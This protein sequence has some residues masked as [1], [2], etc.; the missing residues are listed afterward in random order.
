MKRLLITLAALT[1]LAGGSLFA[2]LDRGSLTGLVTDPSGASVANAQ[3]TATHADTNTTFSTRS[4]E[5]G[6]YTLP[7]LAIGRYRIIV[8]ATGFRRTQRD[9]I[10]VTSGDSLRAD[11]ILELGSVTDSVQV[12]AQASAIQTESTRVATNLTTKLVEDLPLVVAGQIR[13][14]FNLAVIAPEAKS[15]STFRI[16]GG[17]GSGWDMQMDGVSLASGTVTY[18]YE[19][20][21][22]SSV[23][24]DAIAEFNVESSGMKAEYG[25]AM[26]VV[27][28]ATKAGTNQLHG[29]V[30]DY[31]RN[32]A[33]DA[34]GFFAK[35]APVLKQN[36]FG[37]TVGGPVYIPKIYNGKNRTFFFT[38]FEGFRNRSGNLPA[39]FTVPL[40]EMYTGDFR[41]YIKNGPDGV[42]FMMQIYDP[43]ST[44][45]GADGR[46]TRTPFAGN[47]I[48]QA[49]FSSV[50]TKYMSFRD[51]SMVANV[52]GAGIVSNYFRDRGTNIS[53]WTKYSVRADHQ[54]NTS[55]HLSFL[56]MDGTKEDK[57]GA[58]GPPGLPGNLN[59]GQVWSRK[60]IS[61]VSPG[62]APS[63]TASS[64][65]S[66]LRIRRKRASSPTSAAWTEASSGQ[67]SSD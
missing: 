19:R 23:P 54:I 51:P 41:N 30:F 14:V 3:V 42:P 60:N 65:A 67:P 57:F 59:S 63:A 6:N 7:A 28:F 1:V 52:P 43:S 10:T 29:N 22:I 55:N 4:S 20:A 56:L 25:R 16:G 58:D 8:E 62:T 5:S 32:S 24:V 53:P 33:A 26:G 31:M 44:T 34:R 46:Y 64:T 27:S 37:F 18:Q 13:N 21:P 2:Q 66:G 38:S 45:L 15:G 61:A 36:D 47:Q 12:M 49:R 17:Q 11:F 39:Y 35:S 48:P 50:A 40:T 9:N